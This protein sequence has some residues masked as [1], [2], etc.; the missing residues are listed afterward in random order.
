MFDR[1]PYE[2]VLN[3]LGSLIARAISIKI[4]SSY[5]LNGK[6][7]IVVN[8]SHRNFSNIFYC[9]PQGY[10]LGSILF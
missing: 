4:I 8:G 3:N 1:V 2:I 10:V 7:V 9:V 6:E 5:L